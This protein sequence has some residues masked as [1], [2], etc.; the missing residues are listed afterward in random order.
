LAASIVRLGGDPTLRAR[1]GK[2]NFNR[3]RQHYSQPAMIAAYR[4]VY[5][6]ALTASR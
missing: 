3:A 1:L 4:E 2:L 6:Q 5:S